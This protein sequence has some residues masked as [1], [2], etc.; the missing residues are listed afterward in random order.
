VANSRIEIH[1]GGRERDK[2]HREGVND[3][4]NDLEECERRA[5]REDEESAE[6][7]ACD[8]RQQSSSADK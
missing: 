6:K 4:G 8:E 2:R 7:W 5:C 3:S 1:V